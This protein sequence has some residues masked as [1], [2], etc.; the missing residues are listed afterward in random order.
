M[1]KKEYLSGL[2]KALKKAGVQKNDDVIA[3]Y[4]QLFDGKI[5]SGYGEEEIAAYLPSPDEVASEFGDMQPSN[6]LESAKKVLRIVCAVIVH[7]LTWPFITVLYIGIAV[8]ALLSVSSAVWG[9]LCVAAGHGIAI[10]DNISFYMPEMPYI[11]A[12]FFGIAL[13]ASIVLSIA[14]MEGLRLISVR[15]YKVLMRW[16]K[17]ILGKEA[18]PPQLPG[19]PVITP[20]MLKTIHI[21]IIFA[22]VVFVFAAIAGFASMFIIAGSLEPWHVWG[23]IEPGLQG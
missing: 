9:T 22:L 23:W 18:T 19:H 14:G 5:A 11:C 15:L 21:F 13:L 7:I 4:A 12:L 3:E 17:S 2:K 1:D 16:H 8:L 20:K 6:K 10:G